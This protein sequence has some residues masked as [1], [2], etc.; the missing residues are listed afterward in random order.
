LLQQDPSLRINISHTAHASAVA[1][2]RVQDVPSAAST[3]LP[4]STLAT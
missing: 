1:E 3:L 2:R 4:R